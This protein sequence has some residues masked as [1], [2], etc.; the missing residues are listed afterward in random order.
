ML[1]SKTA[2]GTRQHFLLD[3][4]SS[5]QRDTKG[6]VLVLYALTALAKVAEHT[7]EETKQHL[8]KTICEYDNF[9]KTENRIFWVNTDP[10]YITIQ[11]KKHLI[12]P[13]EGVDTL[14]NAIRTRLDGPQQAPKAEM[15][16][17]LQNTLWEV[18][19][20]YI[21]DPKVAST[22]LAVVVSV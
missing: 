7:Q 15:A 6:S 12:A 8:E 9:P 22:A 16:K 11:G 13:V 18:L 5:I 14:F 19:K 3:L 1:T 21:T 4:A 17:V 20:N 2:K 10:I